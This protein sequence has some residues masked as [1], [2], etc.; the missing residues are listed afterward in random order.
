MRFRALTAG[1]LMIFCASLSCDRQAQAQGAL[2]GGVSEEEFMKGNGPS[3][4][5]S[6]LND[7]PFEAGAQ[8]DNSGGPDIGMLP[9]SAFTVDKGSRPVQVRK[10]L[11]GNANDSGGFNGQ[12]MTPMMEAP[13]QAR[14]LSAGVDQSGMQARAQK[15]ADPD[16]TVEMQLAWDAWHKRVAEAIYMRFNKA[17]NASFHNSPP[18][19]CQVAYAV[20]YDGR[21]GNVRI[22]Q[23]STSPIY[24]A[25]LLGI[26]TSI[27]GDPVLQ[28]PPGSKRKMVEK[29]GTFTWNYGQ[30]GFKYTMGDKETV[31]ETIPGGQRPMGFGNM[32]PGGMVPNGM[33]PMGR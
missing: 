29:T 2:K 13:R 22:L 25:M 17:A 15:E 23:Q 31:K 16:Q 11:T 20:A 3:L 4:D 21:I 10:P 6:D 18:L 24:N 33:M 8:Q 1:L 12:G 19:A 32:M 7:D 9:S 5:R 14:P 27:Q 28:F 26:V 30:S